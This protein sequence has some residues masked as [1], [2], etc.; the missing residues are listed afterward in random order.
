MKKYILIGAIAFF[1]MFTLFTG[2]VNREIDSSID[3][4]YS[5]ITANEAKQLVKNIVG[6]ARKDCIF[7]V[8]TYL[9]NKI[10]YFRVHVY[11]LGPIQTDPINKKEY[12]QSFTIG[13]YYVEPNTGVVYIEEGMD[14][15]SDLPHLP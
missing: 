12:R 1:V 9:D 15:E 5:K 10:S 3:S 8:D 6:D 7:E 2:C 4:N 11:S 14:N 13:W